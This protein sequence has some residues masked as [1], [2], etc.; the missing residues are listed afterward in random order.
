MTLP[1][2]PNFASVSASL[3]D[4]KAALIVAHPG[5]ELRVFGWLSHARPQVCVLTDGSGRRL[6]SRLNATARILNSVAASTGP[7]FGRFTD[8]RVYQALLAHDHA[9]FIALA[10]KLAAWLARERIAYVVS[11]AAEGYSSTHDVCRMLCA[12]AVKKAAPIAGREIP[13]YDFWLAAHPATNTTDDAIRLG[14][15]D[16]TWQ[17]KLKHARAYEALHHD[18]NH[19][20]AEFGTEAFRREMLRPSQPFAASTS[21]P[22]Y[23]QFGEQQVAAG[24]Y[25]FV[26]RYREHLLPLAE[27]LQK[28]QESIVA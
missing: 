16:A 24:H 11:D 20:L 3:P 21:A 7:V 27:A 10:D 1:T 17:A 9:S 12:T 25:Q 19:A 5:H 8:Q 22:H 14:L 28:H 23:E 4:G 18:V 15:D 26:I 2:N 6:V 13:H